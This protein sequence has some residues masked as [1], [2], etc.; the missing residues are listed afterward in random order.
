MIW[1]TITDNTAIEAFVFWG[2]MGALVA[3]NVKLT[4]ET[5][6][7]E[8]FKSGTFFQKFL[9]WTSESITNG[10]AGGMLALAVN[11]SILL[12]MISGFVAQFLVVYAV[13]WLMNDS[14]KINFKEL[15]TNLLESYTNGSVTK[16]DE[17]ND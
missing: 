5:T 16:D 1:L 6:K 17:K 13:E 15:L 9:V 3:T 2:V 8:L 10:I 4:H 14:F 12:A 11:R 7:P